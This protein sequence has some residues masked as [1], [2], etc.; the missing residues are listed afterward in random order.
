MWF[1]ILCY[2]GFKFL[3]NWFEKSAQKSESAQKPD[4]DKPS[5]R[6]HP[7]PILRF[8]NSIFWLMGVGFIASGA[9]VYFG[10]KIDQLDILVF[11][12]EVAIGGIIIG[13]DN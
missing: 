8:F 11:P 3:D 12:K 1:T 4:K 5:R 10:Y 6:E 9:Y 7:H 13:V 2:I